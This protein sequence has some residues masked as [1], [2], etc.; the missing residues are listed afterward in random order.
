M[1]KAAL[2][3][4]GLTIVSVN[5]VCVKKTTTTTPSPCNAGFIFSNGECLPY[6]FPCEK[7]NQTYYIFND[8]VCTCD[9]MFNCNQPDMTFHPDTCSCSC[10]GNTYMNAQTNLCEPCIGGTCN[11]YY[12]SEG[13]WSY[14]YCSNCNCGA[15]FG[16]NEQYQECEP[17]P[18]NAYYGYSVPLQGCLS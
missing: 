13:L 7:S 10:S 4:F 6:S 3:L 14:E 9:Y 8:G 1:F 5:C 11:F 2:F 16:W 17:C 18:V 12:N 15:G